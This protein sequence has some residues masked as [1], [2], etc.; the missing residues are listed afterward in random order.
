MRQDR[1]RVSNCPAELFPD[2]QQV[3]RPQLCVREKKGGANWTRLAGLFN[4]PFKT[5]EITQWR[6]GFWGDWCLM[7]LQS[8]LSASATWCGNVAVSN[9]AISYIVWQCIALKES[10]PCWH[11]A[12]SSGSVSSHHKNV[13]QNAGFK[14]SKRKY[15]LF[16]VIFLQISF[17]KSSFFS[18]WPRIRTG[19]QKQKRASFLLLWKKTDYTGRHCHASANSALDPIHNV[20]KHKHKQ[21]NV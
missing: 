11:K 17:D 5:F 20:H 4:G 8:K 7:I 2:W 6:S 12:I 9:V 14:A 21:A 16:K 15:S 19:Q 18:A 10:L 3:R 13:N 1:W